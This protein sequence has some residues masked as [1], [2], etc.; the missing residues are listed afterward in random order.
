MAT[1]K[2]EKQGRSATKPPAQA[3]ASHL[4]DKPAGEAITHSSSA[5]ARAH[6]TRSS[7]GAIG[8]DAQSGRFVGQKSRSHPAP[9]VRRPD[10][11]LDEFTRHP[12]VDKV[13]KRLSE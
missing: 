6:S 7:K 8:R 4:S 12:V 3:S 5:Q 9:S 2:S 1:K 10:T 11:F 13:M